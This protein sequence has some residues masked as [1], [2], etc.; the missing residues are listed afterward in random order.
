MKRYAHSVAALGSFAIILSSCSNPDPEGPAASSPEKVTINADYPEYKTAE[1]GVEAS[2]LIVTGSIIDVRYELLFPDEVDS[3]DPAVNPHYGADDPDVKADELGVPVA[4][5][6]ISVTEVHK[7]EGVAVGD[8]IEVSQLGGEHDGVQYVESGVTYLEPE[9]DN[10]VTLLLAEHEGG[11]PFS[12]IS[13]TQGVYERSGVE[14]IPLS[15]G[16]GI[17]DLASASQL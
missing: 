14:L 16:G 5:S 8:V 10:D 9:I 2:D 12:P 17:D 13:S 6:S 7:G 1:E 11:S 3:T 15:E 4:I